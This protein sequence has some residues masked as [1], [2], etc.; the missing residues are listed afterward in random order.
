MQCIQKNKLDKSKDLI[1]LHEPISYSDF[2]I[3]DYFDNNKEPAY[4]PAMSNIHIMKND[5]PD[6][7]MTKKELMPLIHQKYHSSKQTNKTNP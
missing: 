3:S 1:L 6:K 7:K 4:F 5:F 2:I